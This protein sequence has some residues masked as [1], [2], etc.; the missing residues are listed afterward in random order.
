MIELEVRSRDA[1]ESTATLR[2]RGVVPAIFYGP[3]EAATPIAI[4]ARLLE[5]VWKEAGETTIVK[6]GGIGEPKDTLIHDVQFHPVTGKVLHADFYVLE[7]GKKVKIDVPL[8]W[9]GIAPA[10]KAGHVVVKALHEIEIEV[11]PAELP[12]HLMVDLAALANVGDRILVGDIELPASA[13]LITPA[14]EIVASVTEFKEEAAEITPA[15]ETIILTEKPAE[16]GAEAA[17]E[18]K[19]AEKSAPA[20]KEKK[21]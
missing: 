2:E 7:K 6:L 21:E 5:R 11:A 12:H 18:E 14:D 17:G 1:K 10:E 13:T 9:E 4:E 15:P 16:A 20:G 8:E 19:K 3:K